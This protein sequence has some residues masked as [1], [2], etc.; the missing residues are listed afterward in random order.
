MIVLYIFPYSSNNFDQILHDDRG[1]SGDVLYA[2][3]PPKFFL[4]FKNHS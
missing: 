4:P 1:P 3:S 2:R